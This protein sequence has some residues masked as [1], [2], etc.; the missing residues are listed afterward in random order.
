[1][2]L[3]HSYGLA[4][5][6]DRAVSQPLLIVIRE[7]IEPSLILGIS[8]HALL[9]A[10]GL[11][12]CVPYLPCLLLSVYRLSVPLFKIGAGAGKEWKRHLG[13]TLATPRPGT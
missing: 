3:I 9:C 7:G 11:F 4:L 12:L 10:D 2:L 8:A 1:M 6:F 13:L 5:Q